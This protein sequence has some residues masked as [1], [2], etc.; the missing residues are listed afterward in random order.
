MPGALFPRTALVSGMVETYHIAPAA[1][2]AASLK[3]ESHRPS[4]AVVGAAE[5]RGAAHGD[6]RRAGGRF[7]AEMARPGAS[8][9][10]CSFIDCFIH[11]NS[12][13]GMG[14]TAR[15]RAQ[16]YKNPP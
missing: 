6:V 4:W 15:R 8:F 3:L 11:E 5:V 10:W 13:C 9:A 7:I 14:I 2:G 12:N 1:Q 16:V